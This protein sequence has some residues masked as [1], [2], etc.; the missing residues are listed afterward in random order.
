MEY[1]LVGLVELLLEEWYISGKQ[2]NAHDSKN[3][4]DARPRPDRLGQRH[5]VG[6]RGRRR[7]TNIGEK[8]RLGN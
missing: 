6:R 7:I 5:L 4:V 3:N 8:L 1:V 2:C